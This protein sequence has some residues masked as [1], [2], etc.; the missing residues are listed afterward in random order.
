MKYAWNCLHILQNYIWIMTS[1]MKRKNITKI[2][3]P[4]YIWVKRC[5]LSNIMIL[6][7]HLLWYILFG[8]KL[9][10]LVISCNVRPNHTSV[11]TVGAVQQSGAFY[12]LRRQFPLTIHYNNIVSYQWP[13]LGQ[14][15]A[16]AAE[17]LL[18][19]LWHQSPLHFSSAYLLTLLLSWMLLNHH[20]T[21]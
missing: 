18:V 13:G 11:M 7:C 9:L 10:T 19:L 21:Y 20:A 14:A 15:G 12:A 17:K 1:V 16:T 8:M 3:W 4:T 6:S 5:F 2:C